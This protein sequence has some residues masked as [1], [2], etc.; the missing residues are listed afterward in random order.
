MVDLQSLMKSLGKTKKEVIK[1]QYAC[2][3]LKEVISLTEEFE[4]MALEEKTFS[5]QV[6][7]PRLANRQPAIDE[8]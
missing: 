4:E 2:E 3:S 7:E 1:R 6:V 5:K 8:R